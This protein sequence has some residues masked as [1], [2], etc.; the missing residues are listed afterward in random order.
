MFEYRQYLYDTS[1]VAIDSLRKK[2]Y[3][4]D[5]NILNSRLIESP[6]DF[7][8]IYI[9]RYEGESSP[10]DCSVVYGI[11]CMSTGEKGVYVM[12]NP[13]SDCSDAAKVLFGIEIEGRE[14]SKN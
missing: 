7:K 10:E 5:F 4:L 8:I 2:G 6:Q 14:I 9:I 11:E 12:G 3:D 1:S 13:A